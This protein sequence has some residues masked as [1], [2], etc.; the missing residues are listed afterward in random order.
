MN[1]RKT[2]V[3]AEIELNKLVLVVTVLQPAFSQATSHSNI[4]N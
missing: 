1:Y 4:M 3:E 2:A